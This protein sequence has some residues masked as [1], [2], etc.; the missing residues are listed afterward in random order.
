VYGDDALPIDNVDA[1][2]RLVR[3]QGNISFQ[4]YL[5]VLTLAKLLPY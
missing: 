5:Q 4:H 1:V 3:M 2:D